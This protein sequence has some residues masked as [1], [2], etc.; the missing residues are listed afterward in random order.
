VNEQR[1][2]IGDATVVIREAP[3]DDVLDLRHAILRRGLPRETAV[4]A[5]DSD[6]QALHVTASVDGRVVGCATLLPSTWD[7]EPARQLRGMATAA[8]FRGRGLG[9]AMLEFIEQRVRQDAGPR[10]LWCNARLPASGF[11]EKLGWQTVSAPFD[12]PTVGPHV[13]MVKRV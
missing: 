10:L 7:G 11:Y 9:R 2:R 13:R 5:G 12:I 1:I 4:F 6:A 3:A 8:D